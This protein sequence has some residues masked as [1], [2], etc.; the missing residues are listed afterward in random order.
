MFTWHDLISSKYFFFFFNVNSATAPLVSA[1]LSDLYW[2]KEKKSQLVSKSILLTLIDNVSESDMTHT[3]TKKK[4]RWMEG[5]VFSKGPEE[6]D[7]TSHIIP[8]LKV[9]VSRESSDRG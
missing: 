9:R 2:R 4:G 8:A 1:I 7:K 3:H 6:F 5:Q